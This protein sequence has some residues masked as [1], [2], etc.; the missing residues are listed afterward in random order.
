MPGT[1]R[2]RADGCTVSQASEPWG[3]A[4]QR[5]RRMRSLSVR[6][7]TTRENL[8]MLWESRR[9]RRFEIDLFS[10]DGVAE[11]QVLRVEKVAS[12]AGE[13]RKNFKRLAG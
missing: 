1:P 13:A 12:I 4:I 3:E 10:G 6:D 11:F 9:Q 7:T 8:P 5:G 2:H